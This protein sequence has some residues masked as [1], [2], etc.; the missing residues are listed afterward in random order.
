MQIYIGCGLTHVPRDLF[1]AYACFV[2]ELAATLESVHSVNYALRDSD[3]QLAGRGKD[4]ARLC[5]LWDRQMVEKAEVMVADVS[6]PSTGLGLELQLAESRDIPVVLCYR[7]W[8]SNRAAPVTYE[9]PDHVSHE[10]QIGAGFVSLMVL[11]LPNVFE[12]ISY[13]S[14]GEGIARIA[15][16]IAHLERPTLSR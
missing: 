8:G 9:T 10:L 15:A 11:G 16:A 6:F 1:R 4:Q 12:T 2:N 3:P 14:S 7:D 5:Y 13:E